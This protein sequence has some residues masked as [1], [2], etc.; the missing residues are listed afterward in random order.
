MP[1]TFEPAPREI[2]DLANEIIEE[3]ASHDALLKAKVKIDFIMAHGARNDEGILIGD[4]IRSKGCKA[5]GLCRKLGL[6]D[7]TMGRGDAEIL[8]DADWWEGAPTEERR[9]LLDHEI[10]H[11]QVKTNQ[12]GVIKTDDLGRP[13]L[14][15]RPHDYEFGWFNAVAQRHGVHS[16]ER[17]QARAMVEANGQTYWPGLLGQHAD[18][19][20][21]V[22]RQVRRTKPGESTVTISAPG[23]EPITVSREQFSKM[24]KRASA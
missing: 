4:A 22:A 7:R 18:I 20:E 17:I 14:R 15:L 23:I 13:Q 24:A 6:K 8:I 21:Q 10:Y 1:T 19:T 2:L 16:Q 9:S 5:L 11:I 12:A 3:F